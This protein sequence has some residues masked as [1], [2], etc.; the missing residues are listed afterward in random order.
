V[1]Q[2]SQHAPIDTVCRTFDVCRSSFYYQRHRLVR[3]DRERLELRAKVRTLFK[4]SRGAA[5]SRSLV[6]MLAAEGIQI[7]R[8]K[9]R[10]LMREANLRSK[11]P[12]QHRYKVAKDERPDIPHL[13][14]REFNPQRPNQI[15]CGDITYVWAGNRWIYLAVVLD[16]FARCVVGWAISEHPDA[17][18]VSR[19]LDRAYQL[20][21]KPKGVMFHSDQGSQYGSRMFRQRLWRYQIQQSMSR[22]GCCWD[23]APMERLFRSLKTEWIPSSGYDSLLAAQKDIGVYLMA[24]YNWQRPHTFNGGL[25]P[26]MKEKQLNLLSGN[27]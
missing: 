10:A 4:Q 13:L 22:R 14:N 26:A 9:A 25:S 6:W 24:Y 5:G 18:L 2:L 7:G 19:A 11:Q 3:I 21:G 1:S 17:E 27:C 23:N 16:L 8:Y 15:W 12:G 20:R